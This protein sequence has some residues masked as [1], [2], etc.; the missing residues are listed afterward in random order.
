M[1]YFSNGT[2]G[3]SYEH[4]VCSRCIH[5]GDETK[6]CPVWELHL[7]YNYGQT[8]DK[9]VEL[10]LNTLIPR[11]GVYNDLCSMWHPARAEWAD[12]GANYKAW[13]QKV[14]PMP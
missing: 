13:L 3:E 4:N 2:E 6:M 7:L 10:F 8:D 12:H 14:E 11:R 5:Y 9:H 1:A